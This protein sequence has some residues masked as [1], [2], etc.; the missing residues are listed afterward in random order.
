MSAPPKLKVKVEI[1]AEGGTVP[2][3]TIIL[4]VSLALMASI[5]YVLYLFYHL[6]N[7]EDTYR[8]QGLRIHGPYG[9]T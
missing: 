5:V 9:T 7:V 8:A 4:I 3:N 2:T 6:N 1:T